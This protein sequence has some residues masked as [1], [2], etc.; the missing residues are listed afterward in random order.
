[1]TIPP[2][3]AVTVSVNVPA[4]VPGVPPPDG[5]TARNQPSIQR[6]P[7]PLLEV[8]EAAAKRRHGNVH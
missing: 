5:G 7:M 3:V 2:E 6:P 1:M 8:V 4:G